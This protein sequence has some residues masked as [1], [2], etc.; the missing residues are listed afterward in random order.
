MNTKVDV[1]RL[2]RVLGQLEEAQRDFSEE[3]QMLFAALMRE[4]LN[5]TLPA[6]VVEEA[7]A[8]SADSQAEESTLSDE[9]ADRV[10]K[11]IMG[12]R[13]AASDDEDKKLIDSIIVQAAAPE[14]DDVQGHYW[15][16]EWDIGAPTNSTVYSFYRGMCNTTARVSGSYYSGYLQANFGTFWTHY[17]C[18]SWH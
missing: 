1:D 7:Q 5:D 9:S 15:R 8:V 14:D 6:E 16:F 12:V 10:A 2:E 3:E 4:G 18:Y 13:D 11:A 17:R